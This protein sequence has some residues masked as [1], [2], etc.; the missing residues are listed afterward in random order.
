MSVQSIVNFKS[1]LDLVLKL[2]QAYNPPRTADETE[3]RAKSIMAVLFQKHGLKAE[4]DDIFDV[5]GGKHGS[6]R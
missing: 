3:Q 1:E 6:S 2:E 5:P 4:L